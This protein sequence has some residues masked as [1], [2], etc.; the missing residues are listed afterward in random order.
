MKKQKINKSEF[1]VRLETSWSTVDRI[2]DPECL[3][4]LKTFVKALGKNK[5]SV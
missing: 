3:S 5:K 4:A 2:L 1:V